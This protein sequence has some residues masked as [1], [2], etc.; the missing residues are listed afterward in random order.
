[1]S[2]TDIDER[3]DTI[4]VGGRCAGAVTAMLLARAG[5]RVLVLEAGRAN[6]DTLSAHALMRAGVLHMHRWGLLEAI[7]AAGTPPIHRIHRTEFHY[8]NDVEIVDVRPDTGVTALYAP[9]RT[10]LDQVLA[11]TAERAGAQ[12]RTGAR[13]TEVLSGSDGR[14]SGVRALMR[15][16]RTSSVASAT[17]L[18]APTDGSPPLLEPCRRRSR[19]PARAAGPI[20]YGYWGD[21]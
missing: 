18:W 7:Q 2:H 19:T 15:G 4:V 11:D 3:F 1:M 21:T 14:L 16:S 8:G 13:V 9:R 10:V 6:S 5:Q 12:I 17:S 20:L